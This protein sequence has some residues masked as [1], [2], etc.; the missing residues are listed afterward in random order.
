MRL[1]PFS[2][3]I[4]IV[5]VSFCAQKET[6]APPPIAEV[7]T[8]TV[9]TTPTPPTP[10]IDTT[11]KLVWSDEFNKDGAPDSTKWAYNIGTGSNGWG[12]NEAQFYTNELTN[13]RIENGKLIIEAR[14]ENRGGKSYTSARLITLGKTTWTYGRIEVRAKI[15]KGFGTWPAIWMLGENI[16]SVGWPACGE[17]DIMEH[18]GKDQDVMFWSIHT[19]RLNWTLG[20]QQTFSKRVNGI[21]ND[22]RVFK[23]DWTKERLQF[24]IDDV[25]YFTVNNDGRGV[26]FYPFIA[27]QYLLMNLAI[28]GNFGGST[29]DDSIFPVRMEVDYVRVYQ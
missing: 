3:I 24:Y 2:L 15:P 10:T 16:N 23:L 4:C 18:V 14:K 21:S 9:P 8:P 28:G 17:I 25:L 7:T 1:L 20:T 27:P 5:S 26:D 29:I 22:F 19:K 11:R 12:N 6:P 13:A